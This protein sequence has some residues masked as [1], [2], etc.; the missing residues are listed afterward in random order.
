[1]FEKLKGPFETL[2][3]IF[4]KKTKLRKIG[5][6]FQSQSAEKLERGDPL[7]FLKLHFALKYQKTLKGDPLVTKNSK[8]ITQCRKRLKGGTL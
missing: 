7:G 5:I 3:K 2:R 8:K 1:M 4:E 6:L